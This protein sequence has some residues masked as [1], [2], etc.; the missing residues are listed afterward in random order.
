M[1][2]SYY[3]AL[4][5]LLLTVVMKLGYVRLTGLFKTF[6]PAPYFAYHL[7]QNLKIERLLVA[8]VYFIFL[9]SA[10][11]FFSFLFFSLMLRLFSLICFL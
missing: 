8:H 11:I 5:L 10:V 7:A 6:F 4:L 9:S 3:Y 1:I 2:I